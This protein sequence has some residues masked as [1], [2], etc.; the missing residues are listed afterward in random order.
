MPGD[1]SLL[2]ARRLGE[3]LSS[4][5]KQAA[6]GKKGTCFGQCLRSKM[7]AATAALILRL[8]GTEPRF[9]PVKRAAPDGVSSRKPFA[10]RPVAARM[11]R[12][13]AHFCALAP[14]QT[15]RPV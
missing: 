4:A 14:E 13:C 5:L 3:A 12:L 1:T 2:R 11:L 10:G 7:R 6:A 8:L 9:L 15:E